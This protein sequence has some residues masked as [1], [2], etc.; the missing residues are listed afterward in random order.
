MRIDF[1]G[2]DKEIRSGGRSFRFP[3]G[4]YVFKVVKHEVRPTKD[5]QSRYINWQMQCVTPAF[6][7]KTIYHNTS[8]R[9]DAL[10]NLRN[11]IHACTGRNVAGRAVDFD[12]SAL[13]GKTFLGTTEDDEY[14]NPDNHKVTVKSQLVDLRP[15]DEDDVPEDDDEEEDVE[16]EDEEPEPEPAPK[17]KKSKKPKAQAL[18]EVD[19]DEI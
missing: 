14:E 10:W 5:G 1:G 8:L 6:K 13:Y 3:E 11:L 17:K 19:V 9:T 18:E 16:Y 4:D 7:G 15:P 2:V 12:P